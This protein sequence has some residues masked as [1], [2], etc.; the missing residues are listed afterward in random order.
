MAEYNGLSG[1]ELKEW[2]KQNR[3]RDSEQVF[4]LQTI[5]E[6]RILSEKEKSDLQ[7]LINACYGEKKE[8]AL[9]DSDSI[10]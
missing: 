10:K 1:K 3:R 6:S 2:R 9:A 5:R 8:P 7:C 4:L